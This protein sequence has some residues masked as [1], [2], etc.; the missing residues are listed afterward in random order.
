M[1]T[2]LG[3]VGHGKER[4]VNARFSTMTSHYLFEARA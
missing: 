4:S 2:A 3:K 1:Y